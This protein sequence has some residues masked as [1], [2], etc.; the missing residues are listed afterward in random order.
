MNNDASHLYP[1][2]AVYPVGAF[3]VSTK[4][5]RTNCSQTRSSCDHYYH[6]NGHNHDDHD[7]DN[8]EVDHN[9]D[10]NSGDIDLCQLKNNAA[11]RRVSTVFVAENTDDD[12][13]CQDNDGDHHKMIMN[14]R[15]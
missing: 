10:D 12:A 1:E 14:D 9:A 2:K 8:H 5:P 15:V 6:D 7:L 13:D 3:F 4:L 11:A